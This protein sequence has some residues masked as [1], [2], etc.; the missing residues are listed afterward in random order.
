[1][2][3]TVFYAWQSDLPNATNRGLIERALQSALA[4]LS[5]DG[6]LVED[7]RLDRDT[8][9]VA[10]SPDIEHTIFDKIASAAVFVCDVSIITPPGA[11]RA[12]PN[13]NVL[14]ELGYALRALGAERV[15]MVMNTAFGTPESLPFDIRR[16]RVLTYALPPDAD[17]KASERTRLAE[18][19]TEALRLSRAVAAPAAVPAVPKPA[20]V[21]IEAIRSGGATLRASARSYVRSVLE[22]VDGL[23]PRPPESDDA[24]VASIDA[25]VPL[26]CEFLAVAHELATYG[27]PEAIEEV[28]HLFEGLVERYEFR[29][30]GSY[31]RTDFDLPRFLGHE[32]FVGLVAAFIR[33]E[34][35]SEL[36]HLLATPLFVSGNT[37]TGRALGYGRISAETDLLDRVR[38][39]RLATRGSRRVSIRA[40][41]LKQRYESPPLAP[42]LSWSGFIEAD[43]LLHLR[44]VLMKDQ[45]WWPWSAIYLNAIPQVILRARSRKNAERLA[46]GLGVAS[47]PSLGADLRAAIE[48]FGERYR[49]A[50]WFMPDSSFDWSSIG[51]L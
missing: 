12:T 30:T 21:F 2:S 41:T 11:E 20:A 43:L 24:L 28:L 37:D 19:L 44:G 46:T 27:R 6:T 22:A 47:S 51:S 36:D 40:D 3:W 17:S 50:F 42:L 9:G 29:G 1:M 39:E 16:K 45:L 14:V 33:E 4:S 13:P 26:V 49:G 18:R 5:D 15:V 32:L 25:S 10:G 34:R 31:R 35:W 38:A 23:M 7:P 8:A 48:R